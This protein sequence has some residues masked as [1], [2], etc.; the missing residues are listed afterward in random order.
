MKTKTKNVKCISFRNFIH[1]ILVSIL[2]Y[3]AHYL[4]AQSACGASVNITTTLD[5]GTGSGTAT[6]VISGSLDPFYFYWSNGDQGLG[7]NNVSNLSYGTYTMH[8]YNTLDSLCTVSATFFISLDS[9]ACNLN[10]NVAVSAD[11]GTGIGSAQALISGMS[12]QYN[13]NWYGIGF[14]FGHSGSIISN[15]NSGYYLLEIRDSIN[16]SCTYYD[17][18]FIP[19]DSTICSL[20]LNTVVTPD[21]GLG[22]G[23]AIATVN[24]GSGS[25]HFSWSNGVYG[26][27]VNIINNLSTGSYNVQVVDLLDSTCTAYDNFFVWLDT[28][29]VVNPCNLSVVSF[30]TSPDNGTGNGTATL[31]IGGTSSPLYYVWSNGS[32]GLGLD[33]VN[34]LTTGLYNVYA[35]S[36]L[37]SNCYMD[38]TFFIGYD[39]TYCMLSIDSVG[40]TPDNGCNNGSASINVTGGSGLYYYI[41]TN[42]VDGNGINS[43]YNLAQGNYIVYVVDLTDSLCATAKN[44]NIPYDSSYIGNPCSLSMTFITTPDNGS[45]NGTVTASVTG[46]SG[47]YQFVWS[48]GLYGLD[49]HTITNLSKGW[50]SVQVTD[51]ND[52]SAT[53]A[54]NFYISSESEISGLSNHVNLSNIKIYPNPV[55]DILNIE[56]EINI[57]TIEI[58][59][60]LGNLVKKVNVSNGLN[61]SIDLSTLEG[62]VYML[63]IITENGLKVQKMIKH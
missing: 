26:N 22:N 15:V 14:S 41:W 23:T 21:Y 25:Y 34:N 1:M 52:P 58:Y 40:I 5:D 29:N 49:L 18:I 13:V 11:N 24:G 39:S 55:S 50:Y 44:I 59:S 47:S 51:I 4:K 62:N 6:A 36:T 9:N 27:G 31:T 16:Y 57:L 20:T 7:L 48:N 54:R 10:V 8:A 43:V 2:F 19:L 33:F 28:S 42:G 61:A 32:Q 56:S 17:T 3:Q 38:T 45:N 37:D 46:G 35:Y 12:G 30:N 60:L 53:V 63:H